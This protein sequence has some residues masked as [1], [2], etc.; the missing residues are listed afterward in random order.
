MIQVKDIVTKS[1]KLN[2]Q[3][4]SIAESAKI[5]AIIIYQ[6]QIQGK[7]ENMST[8]LY[9]W[10]IY[11]NLKISKYRRFLNLLHLYLGKQTRYPVAVLDTNSGAQ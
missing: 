8:V 9:K 4:T 1:K 6:C 11:R 10:L 3:G 5:E 2:N 7:L